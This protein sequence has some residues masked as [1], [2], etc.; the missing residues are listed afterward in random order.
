MGILAVESDNTRISDSK[1]HLRTTAESILNS[2]AIVP[3]FYDPYSLPIAGLRVITH[4]TGT[5]ELFTPREVIPEEYRPIVIFDL[6]DSVWPH[7]VHVVRAISEASGLPIAMEEFRHYGHT[8]KVPLWAND[9][10]IPKIQDEIQFGKHP[11]YFPFVNPAWPEAVAT[12]QAND[13]MGHTFCYLTA[14]QPEL[15]ETTVKVM[16][17]NGMPHNHQST[18]TDALTMCPVPQDKELYCVH[19]LNDV[20]GYKLA[21]VKQWLSQLRTI[22]WKGTMVVVDDLLKPFQSLV[23][24]REILGISLHGDL[25][26]NFPPYDGEI[27]EG[28]WNGISQRLM[29]VHKQAVAA[30]PN[31]YR[32]FTLDSMVPGTLL[33]VDKREAGVGEFILDTISNYA[34]VPA[35]NWQN[36]AQKEL[37]RLG[38][39]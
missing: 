33:V 16:R 20:N 39:T 5:Q 17:W 30:D 26:A 13:R 24:S 3:R 1:L 34:F 22:G 2:G 11:I 12:I 29:E 27:R 38:F 18:N 28:S 7:V 36:D 6:D 32:A 9:T 31:P 35:E 25:N 8:R 23:E 21:V 15:F 19:G 10:A 37:S 4:E 14:R